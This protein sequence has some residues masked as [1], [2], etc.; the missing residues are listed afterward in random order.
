M[1]K[2]IIVCEERLKTYGTF[3]SQLIS[4]KDDKGDS[5]IGI[6]DGSTAAQVWTEK[7]Y[8][9][10][11][12]QISSEQYILF[13]GNSSLIKEKRNFMQEKFSRYGMKYGWLGKQGV[14]FVESVVPADEYDDFIAFA[15][16]YQPEIKA[17]E[18]KNN[19]LKL[20]YI[21]GDVIDT[22]STE[23]D[24]TIEEADVKKKPFA[25][26]RFL[27]DAARDIQKKSVK[28][29]NTAAKNINKAAVDLNT[30]VNSKKIED[31]EYSCLTLLFYMQGLSDFLGFSEET[32]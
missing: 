8:A 30:A 5:V 32:L 26:P 16:E 15:T 27:R 28:V 9:S 12:A 17:L 25:S 13:I 1:K 29:L 20:P 3:L 11:A 31:Q 22:A 6:K 2:L 23:I 18:E 7:E 14:I 10:N 21:T 24:K 19:V 4:L